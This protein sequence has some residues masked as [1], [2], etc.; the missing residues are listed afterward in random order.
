[1][2]K[3][4]ILCTGSGGFIVGNFIRQTFYNKKPYIISSLDRVRDSHTHNIYVNQDHS[5]HIADILDSHILNVIIKKEEPDIILHGASGNNI[6]T[7]IIGTQNIIDACIINNCRL[8]YLSSDTVYGPLKND[9]EL[10]Y[11]ETS[12]LNPKTT[13]AAHKTCS[14]ILIQS[15]KELKYNIL[16]LCNNYGPWQSKDKFIPK[17]IKSILITNEPIPLY[18]QGALLREW[19]HVYDTCSAIFDVIEKAPENEIYNVSYNQ[20][21]MNIEIFQMICNAIGKGHNLLNFVE[22]EVLKSNFR[23]SIKSEKLKN[24][25]WIPKY[26]F[27][28]T[29][30][31]VCQWYVNNNFFLKI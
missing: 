23:Y 26:K 12:P 3:I 14:E 17:I 19:L 5:F 8:I 4:K 6:N 15:S 29:I 24:I 22:D 11:I 16:R 2:K 25:G 30:T 9:K 21:F 1:M 10:P 18:S 31:S 28:E 7:N 13:N 20:E 27:K